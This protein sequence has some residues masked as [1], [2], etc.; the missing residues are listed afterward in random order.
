MSTKIRVRL[1]C[2]KGVSAGRVLV[3]IQAPRYA[4]RISTRPAPKNAR[5]E[6]HQSRTEAELCAKPLAQPPALTVRHNWCDFHFCF[7][8]RHCFFDSASA[9][10]KRG[11]FFYRNISVHPRKIR[12]YPRKITKK[13]CAVASQKCEARYVVYHRF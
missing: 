7:C 2:V 5:K 8:K 1:H 9:P 4:R 3:L 13:N 12:K 10:R 6:I 11:F